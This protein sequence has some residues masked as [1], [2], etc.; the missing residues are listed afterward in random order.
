VLHP[1]KPRPERLIIRPPSEWRSMLIRSTRGCRWNR[2][3]FCGIYP[4]L[5]EPFFSVC[6]LETVKQDIDWF[7]QRRPALSTAFL[8]DADPL[9]REINESEE[10][11]RFLRR[12]NPQLR[13]VTAYGR[14]ATILQLGEDG[15]SRLATSGLNRIHLGLESR[16]PFTLEF[17]C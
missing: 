1:K 4:A 10:I 9:C 8:G 6:T 7:R 13:R 2:C 12:R 15:L 16:D 17:H 11:L 3:K 14:A 5:G